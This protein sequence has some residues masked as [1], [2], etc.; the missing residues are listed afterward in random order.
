MDENSR[1]HK[2]FVQEAATTGRLARTEPNVQNVPIRTP[3][4][5]EIRNC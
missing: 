3:L 2:T 1:L 5:R 4:G